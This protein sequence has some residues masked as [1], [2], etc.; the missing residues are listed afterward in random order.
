MILNENIFNV[1]EIAYEN[2]AADII[3]HQLQIISPSHPSL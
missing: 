3:S 1:L 2:V